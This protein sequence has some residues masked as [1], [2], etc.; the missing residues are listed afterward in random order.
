MIAPRNAVTL[1]G[2]R[3]AAVKNLTRSF[4]RVCHHAPMKKTKRIA[5]CKVSDIP[6]NGMKQVKAQG[7]DIC[8]L[9][10]GD[11]F[12]ACQAVCPHE[13][14]PL[15][16]GVFDGE[17]LTCVEHLWQWSLL[18]DGEPRGLAETRLEM[19]GVEVDA[20]TVYLKG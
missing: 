7:K 15:C 16:N 8:V 6:A 14:V 1:A 4:P 20:G 10:G 5:I 18:E 17:T 19:Y 3:M 9:N 13:H 2:T 11:R 12:F